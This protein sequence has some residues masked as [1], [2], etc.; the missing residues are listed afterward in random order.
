MQDSARLAN[1]IANAAGDQMARAWQEY[2]SAKRAE[3]IEE[4]IA[5]GTVED[6]E[7]VAHRLQMI[8]V[9]RS[10]TRGQQ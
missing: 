6:R 8:D 2:L 1:Q 7:E 9:L 5:A 4:M 3:L 10:E